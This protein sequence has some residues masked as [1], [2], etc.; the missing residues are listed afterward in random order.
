MQKIND[1]DII[2]V[3]NEL[4][5]IANNYNYD[6]DQS[7]LEKISK[8]K[9]RFFGKDNF[10]KCPCYPQTDI[11]HGCG[12]N[13]CLAEIDIT[14]TCHCNLFKLKDLRKGT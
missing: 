12:S 11:E 8:A 14:G 3:K 2:F 4:S 6:I 13:K 7:N 9:L 5:K 10:K 1:N